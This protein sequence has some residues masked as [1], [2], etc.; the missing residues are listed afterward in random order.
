MEAPATMQ[1]E[2]AAA[3]PEIPLY[4]RAEATGVSNHLGGYDRFNPSSAGPTWDVEK[5]SFI[6]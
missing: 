2:L 5:W 4:Y 3:L 1:Q 6:P